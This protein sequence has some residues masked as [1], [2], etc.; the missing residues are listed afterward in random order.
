[1]KRFYCHEQITEGTEICSVCG[2][3]QSKVVRAVI[4][5]KDKA[6]LSFSDGK[7]FEADLSRVCLSTATS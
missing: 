1:M 4:E 7:V 6:L 5:T 2:L 3:P